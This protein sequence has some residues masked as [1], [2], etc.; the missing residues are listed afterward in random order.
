[1]YLGLVATPTLIYSDEM[2]KELIKKHLIDSQT[3]LVLL[4]CC[5]YYYNNNNN[6]IIIIGLLLAQGMCSVLTLILVC[7]GS[8][9]LNL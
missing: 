2:V 9:T 8:R 3:K 4:L 1:M 7:N 6:I 5:Y